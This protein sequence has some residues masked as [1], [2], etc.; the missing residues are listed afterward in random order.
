MKIT[1]K[2]LAVNSLPRCPEYDYTTTYELG[3]RH[4]PL[5]RLVDGFFNHAPVRLDGRFPAGRNG[6]N[7]WPQ[8]TEVYNYINNV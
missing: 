6:L 3:H 5:S 1:H 8:T 4:C 2:L 7:P